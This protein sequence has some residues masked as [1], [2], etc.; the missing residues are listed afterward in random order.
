[1]DKMKLASKN[2]LQ[3][4]R[5]ANLV[6]YIILVG[7]IALLCLVAFRQFGTAVQGRVEAQTSQVNSIQ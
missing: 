3:D 6:E 5:G 7:V 2:L 1:M 4:K